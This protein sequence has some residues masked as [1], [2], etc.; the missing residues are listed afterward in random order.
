MSNQMKSVRSQMEQD[1][2]LKVLMAGF[3]GSNIDESDFASEGVRMN[4]M[5]MTVDEDFDEQLP[6]VYDPD[7]ISAYWDKR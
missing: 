5:E 7:V 6:L 1:E 2:Q 4:L 3:R